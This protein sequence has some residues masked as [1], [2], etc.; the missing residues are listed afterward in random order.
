MQIVVALVVVGALASPFTNTGSK[1]PRVAPEA[2]ASQSGVTAPTIE[3][4]PEVRAPSSE[5]TPEVEA[6]TPPPVVRSTPKPKAPAPVPRPSVK[7]KT[8]ST[9]DP[10]YSGACLKP[11]VEDYDC[12][13]GSGN[14]PYYVEGPIRVV[15]DDHYRLDSDHD[16]TACE[17]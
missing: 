9:C 17:S 5:P 2:A 11:N 1:Q 16:G 8:S 3:P 7:K 4:T 13:G 15:G 10:N 12:A 6:T 14:G